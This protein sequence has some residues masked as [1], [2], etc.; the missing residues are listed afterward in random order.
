VLSNRVLTAWIAWP[1]A[2]RHASLI[3][4]AKGAVSG[5][6][7]GEGAVG[8]S[9]AGVID[10]DVQQAA[11]LRMI[12]RFEQNGV[13]DRENSGVASDSEGQR[14]NSGDSKHGVL[15]DQSTGMQKIAPQ[16]DP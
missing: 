14:Q 4:T 6:C 10:G 2:A 5:S 13:D 15:A 16:K 8:E 11:G 9:A 1:K 12:E 7:K 3:M